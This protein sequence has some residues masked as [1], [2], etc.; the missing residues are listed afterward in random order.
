[1]R[2]SNVIVEEEQCVDL[3]DNDDDDNNGG[4]NWFGDIAI[5]AA[6]ML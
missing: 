3:R 2:C 1:M 6:T 4:K 5:C